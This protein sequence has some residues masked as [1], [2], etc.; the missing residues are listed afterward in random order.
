MKIPTRKLSTKIVAALAAAWFA[1]AALTACSAGPDTDARPWQDQVVEAGLDAFMEY[2]EQGCVTATDQQIEAYT[3][4]RALSPEIFGHERLNPEMC[5]PV[6]A[7]LPES[8][9]TRTVSPSPAAVPPAPA[10]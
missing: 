1:G 7:T 2:V 5:A 3:V 4:A 8:T 6:P 10:A 9:A